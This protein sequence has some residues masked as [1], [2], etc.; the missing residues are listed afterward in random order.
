PDVA[1]F[2]LARQGAGVATEFLL[3]PGEPSTFILRQVEGDGDSGLM[4]AR[5]VGTQPL[6]ETLEFWRR[7]VSKCR[8]DG[9]WREM[10]NRSALML[11]L[12]TFVPTGAIVAAP[13]CS[14]RGDRRGGAL[15]LPLHLGPRR[16]IYFVRLPAPGADERGR[17][18]HGLAGAARHRKSASWPLA[19]YVPHR[20][21][22]RNAG[23]N[24]RPPGRLPWLA[25]GARRQW[26]LR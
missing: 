23:G 25:P 24:P 13:T 19:D 6:T 1:I 5:L 12:L 8:Y 16:G 26:R 11:K 15:G 7:W 3:H 14:L 22:A 4:E 17:A 20:W 18:L 2:P 10:V 9:R 21:S